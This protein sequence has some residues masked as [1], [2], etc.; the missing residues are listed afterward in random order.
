M[1]T[2]FGDDGVDTEGAKEPE[3][4][5]NDEEKAEESDDGGDEKSHWASSIMIWEACLKSLSRTLRR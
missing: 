2:A 1:A 5:W 4:D 3:D